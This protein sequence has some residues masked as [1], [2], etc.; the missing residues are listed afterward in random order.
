MIFETII[1]TTTSAGTAHLTPLG[2]TYADEQILL[3]PFVPS[4]TLDNLENNSHATL[5][6]VD[7]VRVFAGCLTGRRDWPLVEAKTHKGWRLKNCLAHK[8]LSV[9]ERVAD[10]VRP[11]FY[12][13]V[14]FEENHRAFR[15]YNRAQGAVIEAAILAT[16]L[17]FLEPAKIKTEMTYLAIAIDKTAGQDEHESWRWIVDLIDAHPSH[18]G[19][20]QHLNRSRQ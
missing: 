16:R 4:T 6:M 8:E 7:D 12:C 15:G 11:K 9:V 18:R 20:K 2:Y 13:D 10:T 14:L 17:D 3:A 1:C 5:N 19:L